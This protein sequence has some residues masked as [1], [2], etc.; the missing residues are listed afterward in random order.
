DPPI[1]TGDLASG[2][3]QIGQ[4]AVEYAGGGAVG[5]RGSAVGGAQDNHIAAILPGLCFKTVSAP[6]NPS[7]KSSAISPGPTRRAAA[8]CNQTAAAAASK[9]G[10]PCASSPT[11]MPARTSPE[12]AV[13]SSGGA[14]S[15]IAA[16]PSGAAITV[17]L[18]FSST[19]APLIAAARQ[20]LSSLLLASL[21]PAGS[22]SRANSPSCGVST[23]SAPIAA[24][25]TGGS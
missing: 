5:H 12:P 7:T 22:N 24:N 21:P 13:A 16:R 14:P 4:G 3:A 15:L 17:S 8:P 23:Q 11:T 10:M 19:T 2:T 20:A 25:S 18:P 1:R 6:G 9:A